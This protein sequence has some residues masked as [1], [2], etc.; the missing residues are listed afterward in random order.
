MLC[1]KLRCEKSF[2]LIIISFKGQVFGCRGVRASGVER[3]GFRVQRG[4]DF[5]CRRVRVSGKGLGCR[6]VR[7]SG[8][9]GSG[10]RVKRGQVVG[11]RG[12]R[13]SNEGCWEQIT[14]F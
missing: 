7:V 4:Q 3:S 11:C 5:G 14:R 10:F 8:L 12:A 9:E 13:I 6:G 2:N 1:S